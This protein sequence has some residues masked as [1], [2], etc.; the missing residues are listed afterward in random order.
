MFKKGWIFAYFVLWLLASLACGAGD[1]TLPQVTISADTAA[2]AQA[3]AEQAGL[4]AATAAALI[5]TQ[6]G[7]LLATVQA[8]DF[9]V[10][11][12][13]D[14]ASLQQRFA[15]VQFDGNGNVSVTVTEEEV[16]LAL[17]QG[18]QV[19]AQNGQ[20]S[21]LQNPYLDLT[22]GNIVLSG[23]LTQPIQATLV[24]AFRPVVVNNV[25]QFEIVS[26]TL[27]GIQVP[28]SI[29]ASVQTNLNNTLGTAFSTLPGN[30]ILK[31]VQM[32]EGTM[33]IIAGRP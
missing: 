12:H 1:V 27:G 9:N 30:I 3:A 19:A 26:A 13:L 10:D 4:A 16:N 25:L 7:S 5:E 8:G 14:P 21:P 29:L 18:E 28:P 23:D 15:N 33:T 20:A 22:G 24:A 17:Q 11:L 2:T 32:G 31:E 6:G